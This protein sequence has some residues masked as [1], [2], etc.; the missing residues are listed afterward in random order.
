MER[1]IQN[2]FDIIFPLFDLSLLSVSSDFDP[3]N[4]H[5]SFYWGQ[6]GTHGTKCYLFNFPLPSENIYTYID[7]YVLLLSFTFLLHKKFMSSIIGWKNIYVQKRKRKR[8]AK[9]GVDR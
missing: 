7:I 2:L 1:R 6:K 4:Q 8:K 9:N 3:P 5:V